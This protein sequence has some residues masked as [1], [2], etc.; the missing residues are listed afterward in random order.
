MKTIKSTGNVFRDLGF[1]I[2]EEA[3]LL[4]RSKLMVEIKKYI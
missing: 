4:I 1:D 2:E 3:N